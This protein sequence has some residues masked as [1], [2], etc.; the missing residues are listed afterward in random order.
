MKSFKNP[1][2]RPT[3]V[4]DVVAHAAAARTEVQVP[5]AARVGSVERRTPNVAVV[6]YIFD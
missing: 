4:T 2:Y 5:S 6:A 1:T 3:V